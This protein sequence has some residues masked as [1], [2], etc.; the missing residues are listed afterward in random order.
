MK[1][2]DM[3]LQLEVLGAKYGHDNEVLIEMLDGSGGRSLLNMK[4]IIVEKDSIECAVIFSPLLQHEDF[5][6]GFSKIVSAGMVNQVSER[7]GS[8][9]IPAGP[10]YTFGKSVSLQMSSRQWDR[11]VLTESLN[12]EI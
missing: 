9:K 7:D 5:L 4:Y 3:I 8:L 1:I 10:Y 2:E 12:F 11:H 6:N